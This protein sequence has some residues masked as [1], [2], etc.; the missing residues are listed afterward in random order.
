MFGRFSRTPK[1]PL[2]DSVLPELA[3]RDGRIGADAAALAAEL[4]TEHQVFV[5]LSRREA[6]RIVSYMAERHIPAGTRFIREGDDADSDHMLLLLEGSATVEGAD[7]GGADTVVSVINPGAVIGELGLLDG[8][9]RSAS[10]VASTDLLVAVLTRDHL[11]QLID[12]HPA[13]G[14]KLLLSIAQRI[15]FRLRETTLRMRHNAQ[16]LRA[17]EAEMER[18]VFDS[19]VSH[20]D[21]PVDGAGR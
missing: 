19:M 15:A 5:D 17:L 21:I 11:M 14:N 18:R 3:A 12:D 7:S 6:L 1:A 10:C 9:P 2:P 20:P 16:L 8:G 4:L 13:L